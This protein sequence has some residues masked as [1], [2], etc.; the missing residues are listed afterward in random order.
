MTNNI[1][2]YVDIYI[3]TNVCKYLHVPLGR[4]EMSVVDSTTP[5]AMYKVMSAKDLAHAQKMAIDSG[6]VYAYIFKHIFVWL[7]YKGTSFTNEY[8]FYK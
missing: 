7:R 5:K 3:S 6:I 8:I 1:C 4:L 2:I